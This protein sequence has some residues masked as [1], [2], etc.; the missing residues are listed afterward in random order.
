MQKHYAEHEEEVVYVFIKVYDPQNTLY[1]S[2][3]K[4]YTYIILVLYV[5]DAN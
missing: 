4:L 3:G 2:Y 5:N 1:L